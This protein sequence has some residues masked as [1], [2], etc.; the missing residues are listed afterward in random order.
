MIPRFTY[1]KIVPVYFSY[2]CYMFIKILNPFHIQKKFS[3]CMCLMFYLYTYELHFSNIF[4]PNTCTLLGSLT[5]WILNT[6]YVYKFLC[7]WKIK[8]QAVQL[9]TM[10]FWAY[11]Y[12]YDVM[13]RFLLRVSI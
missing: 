7:H 2:I 3:R 11:A 8:L 4:L 9:F 12:Y 1:Y 13:S 10:C 5:H 6:R